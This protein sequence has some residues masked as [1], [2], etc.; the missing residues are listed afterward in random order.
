MR[1]GDSFITG[2][3][4]ISAVTLM[5]LLLWQSSVT[6]RS[7]TVINSKRGGSGGS[8]CVCF[9]TLIL[10]LVLF[11]DFDT[12]LLAVCEQQ[13][14]VLKAGLFTVFLQCHESV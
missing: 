8:V 9:S 11:E 13:V 5:L 10:R 12:M 3:V 7:V 2:C 1:T 4:C 14:A 6:S